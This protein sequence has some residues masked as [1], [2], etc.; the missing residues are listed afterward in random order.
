MSP[1]ILVFRDFVPRLLLSSQRELFLLKLN[2]SSWLSADVGVG[3]ATVAPTFVGQVI[4]KQTACFAS[5]YDVLS[6]FSYLS[7]EVLLIPK[8]WKT[9]TAVICQEVS[10]LFFN[11]TLVFVYFI[12]KF[13]VNLP[14]FIYIAKLLSLFIFQGCASWRRLVSTVSD[15]SFF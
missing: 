10:K 1:A 11:Q 15:G 8:Y 5:C 3:A 7:F 13:T 9:S 2:S 12:N 14:F 6:S 4:S